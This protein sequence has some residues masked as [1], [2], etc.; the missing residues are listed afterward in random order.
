MGT[1]TTWHLSGFSPALVRVIR[2]QV[3]GNGAAKS[4]SGTA[5][6]GQRIT[7]R[8]CPLAHRCLRNVAQEANQPFQGMSQ[9]GQDRKLEP[10]VDATQSWSTCF[11][12]THVIGARLL[13]F[14]G[15]P[16][17]RWQR[18]THEYATLLVP[19]LREEGQTAVERVAPRLVL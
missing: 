8:G 4:C 7:Y 15:F 3:P 5:W 17:S 19:S 2:C 14:F 12:T 11:A 13:H 9:N 6:K 10:G 18:L 1:L 16:G